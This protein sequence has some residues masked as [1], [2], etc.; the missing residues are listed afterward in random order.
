LRVVPRAGRRARGPAGRRG[1]VFIAS[2][3]RSRNR[4]KSIPP[5]V[6]RRPVDG[7]RRCGARYR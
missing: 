4:K 2:H 6:F 5:G 1:R 3:R 7:L